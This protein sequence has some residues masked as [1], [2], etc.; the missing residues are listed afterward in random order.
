MNVIT[1]RQ[2]DALGV[3]KRRHLAYPRH[4]NFPSCQLG[5]GTTAIL[6]K[7]AQQGFVTVTRGGRGSRQFFAITEIGSAATIHD[8]AFKCFSCSEVLNFRSV[9]GDEEN[10]AGAGGW[11][12]GHWEGNGQ[13]VCPGCKD[14]IWDAL[15]L[16]TEE[17][18]SR[19]AVNAA[20]TVAP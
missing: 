12:I 17:G 15:P 19:L 4:A 7:L 13:F 10:H 11:L 1:H 3:L 14:T 5:T 16:G 18:R 8:C 2:R 9:I 6:R 20:E